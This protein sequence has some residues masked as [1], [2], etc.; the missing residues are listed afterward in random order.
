MSAQK[1]SGKIAIAHIVT[2]VGV[3]LFLV[4]S[5][6]GNYFQHGSLGSSILVALLFAAVFCVLAFFLRYAKSRE[7]DLKKWKIVEFSTLGAYLVLAVVLAG[8]LVRFFA[9][10]SDQDG[11]KQQAHEDITALRD[12]LNQFQSKETDFVT[13]TA[14]GIKNSAHYKKRDDVKSFVEGKI[15]STYQEEKTD[16]IQS[17][18]EYHSATIDSVEAV[19][20]QWQLLQVPKS[21]NRIKHAAIDIPAQLTEFSKENND[22]HPIIQTSG[23]MAV[24]VSTTPTEYRSVNV[25]LPQMVEHTDKITVGAVLALILSHVLILFCYIMGYR[26]KRVGIMA[27]KDTNDGGILL[28][29]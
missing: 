14:T 20:T 9:I 25:K 3:A 1:Q 19:I 16:E 24:L 11:I 18:V 4:F 22:E 27:N 6:I 10:T 8:P 12:L 28:K 13:V 21:V 7:N 23:S 29:F 17:E 5:L 26:S 2:I 15:A